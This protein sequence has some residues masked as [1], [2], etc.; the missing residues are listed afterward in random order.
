LSLSRVGRAGSAL[1]GAIE[2]GPVGNGEEGE[3][4]DYAPG[5]VAR[6]HVATARVLKG[7]KLS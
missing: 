1:R 7:E 4:R 5:E 3:A 6:K 2:C